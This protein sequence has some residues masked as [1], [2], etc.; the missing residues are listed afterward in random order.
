MRFLVFEEKSV[1]SPHEVAALILVGSATDHHDLS[2]ADLEALLERR[3]ATF[4]QIAPNTR[5]VH[6][7]EHGQAILQ[8][9]ARYGLH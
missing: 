2:H 5:R 6:L 4:E 9:V 8:A 1:L 7:T 3:L